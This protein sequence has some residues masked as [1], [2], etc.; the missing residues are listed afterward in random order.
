MLEVISIGAVHIK[1]KSAFSMLFSRACSR[2]LH[3]A[4]LSLFESLDESP[5]CLYGSN[6]TQALHMCT[7]R[8]QKQQCSNT[9]STKQ[10]SLNTNFR[11]IASD[12]CFHTS[13]WATL[14]FGNSVAA[15]C[16]MLPRIYNTKTD[17]FS[18]PK[19]MT[20]PKSFWCR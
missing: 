2:Q 5:G 11:V 13:P 20:Y 4:V 17:F 10:Q 9:D 1:E 3:R 15:T 18:E 14:K 8:T 16:A 6:R 7:P 12:I 19:W